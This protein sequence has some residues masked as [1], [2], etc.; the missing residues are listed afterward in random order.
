MHGFVGTLDGNYTS[1]DFPNGATSP[2]AINNDG[3]ITGYASTSTEECPAFGCEFIRAPNGSIEPITRHGVQL[4]GIAQGIIK[5]ARFVGQYII[6]GENGQ[7]FYYGY[8]GK[9][10][11][12]RAALTLPFNTTRTSPRGYNKNGTVTGYFLDLDNNNIHPGFVLKAG[13]AT[14][15]N[16]P[17]QKATYTLLEGVNDKGMIAGTWTS[18]DGSSEQAFLFDFDK[19]EFMPIS[20][21]GAMFSFAG[22]INNNDVVAVTDENGVS[23]IYCLKKR[24]C[25]LSSKAT[26]ILDHWI[27][28]T[29]RSAFCRDGCTG[30]LHIPANRKKMDAASIHNAIGRDP[31]FGP[32]RHR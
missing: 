24:T 20:I 4:D 9:G 2:N 13:V 12:Y 28:A 6:V 32:L 19:N 31:E 30:P 11:K 1:F 18:N 22:G 15:V 14:A 16:Y 17:D 21:P 8:Y 25:P 29:T 23:Y 10:A 27:P 3:Y 26:E 5:N 7:L